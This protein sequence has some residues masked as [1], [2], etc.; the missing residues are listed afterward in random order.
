MLPF[1]AI[2]FIA[3]FLL[4]LTATVLTTVAAHKCKRKQRKH[5]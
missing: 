5:R 1:L 2:P 3:E 4:P